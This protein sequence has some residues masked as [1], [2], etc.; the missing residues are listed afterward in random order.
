MLEGV[1]EDEHVRY[2]ACSWLCSPHLSQNQPL[3]DGLNELLPVIPAKAGTQ[4]PQRLAKS[5]DPSFRW[6]GDLFRRSLSR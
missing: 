4:C 1:F 5:L 6:N 2:P 3:R